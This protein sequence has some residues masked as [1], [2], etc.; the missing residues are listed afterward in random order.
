MHD[1]FYTFQRPDRSGY[2]VEINLDGQRAVLKAGKTEQEAEH[3]ALMAAAFREQGATLDQI[4]EKIFNLA[5]NADLEEES[6]LE[7]N[8]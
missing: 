6:I 8:T 5:L 1:R 4:V 7:E 3:K 2:Y